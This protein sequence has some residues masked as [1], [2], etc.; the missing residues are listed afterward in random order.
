[1][2]SRRKQPADEITLDLTPDDEITP[3]DEITLDLTP[4]DEQQAPAP[5]DLKRFDDMVDIFA[6]ALK[7]RARQWH[8]GGHIPIPDPNGPYHVWKAVL[9]AAVRMETPTWRHPDGETKLQRKLQKLV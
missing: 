7:D 9:A 6:E 2:T 3:A 5:D 4:D 8:T 1:M